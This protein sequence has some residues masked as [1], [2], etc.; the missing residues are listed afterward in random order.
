MSFSREAVSPM[1]TKHRKPTP[2]GRTEELA[3]ESVARLLRAAGRRRR[4]PT[5]DMARAKEAARAEWHRTVQAEQWQAT[6]F[7]RRSGWVWAA[8]AFLLLALGATLGPSFLDHLKPTAAASLARVELATGT[9]ERLGEDGTRIPLVGGDSLPKGSLIETDGTASNP[10]LA[11]LRLAG[12]ASLRLA[13][14]SRLHLLSASVVALDRGTVYIDSQ[15][16]G[17]TL[18][19][20]TPLGIARDIGTQF[21]VHLDPDAAFLRLRV[22]SGTVLLSQGAISHTTHAGDEVELSADGSL[23]EGSCPSHG[24]AWRWVLQAMPA[25]TTEGKSLAQILRWAARE[26]GWELRFASPTV[27]HYAEQT[28]MLGSTKIGSPEQ[29][30]STALPA[31]GGKL[32]HRLHN[33]ILEIRSEE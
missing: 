27:E 1:N 16:P 19:V 13:A 14:G 23:I 4:L 31:S 32:T 8:A 5:A 7:R 24:D 22:R 2:E 12:G 10:S 21:E 20:R 3:D 9:I 6:G 26:G 18:E 29:A 33:G 30:L 25:F 28:Q 15:Q 17:S 11:A